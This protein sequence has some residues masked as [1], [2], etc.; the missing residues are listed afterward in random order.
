MIETVTVDKDVVGEHAETSAPVPV[1]AGTYVVV[2]VDPGELIGIAVASFPDDAVWLSAEVLGLVR[3]V[4][5]DGRGQWGYRV[6]DEHEYETC[7]GCEGTGLVTEAVA[8]KQEDD[9]IDQLHSMY[10]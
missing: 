7:E 4:E 2:D 6:Y 10:D 3:C 5:C 1:V 8:A 9:R